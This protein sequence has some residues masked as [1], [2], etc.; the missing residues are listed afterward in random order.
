MKHIYIIL[1]F[2][3]SG[4]AL[5]NLNAQSWNQFGSFTNFFNN[6]QTSFFNYELD[7]VQ[8]DFDLEAMDLSEAIDGL[9]QQIETNPLEGGAGSFDVFW[10][11]DNAFIIDGGEFNGDNSDAASNQNDNVNNVWNAELDNLNNGINGYQDELNGVN[12]NV[13]NQGEAQA[14]NAHGDTE[15]AM[16]NMNGRTER[17][18]KYHRHQSTDDIDEVFIRSLFSSALDLELA[19]GIEFSDTY[20]WG[21]FYSARANLIRVASVPTFRNNFETS[22]AFETSFMNGNESVEQETNLTLNAG[23]NTL[24]YHGEFSFLFL[25]QLGTIGGGEFRLYT[26]IG[27]D[28][29]S[30]APSHVN[31]RFNNR[32]GMTTGYGAQ[33]GAG[34][35][36]NLQAVSI[37]SYGTLTRGDVEV[38]ATHDGYDYNAATVNAGIRI[39]N[40][41]N[42]RYTLGQNSWAFDGQKERNFNRFTVGL[43]LDSL[44]RN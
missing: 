21:D 44:R 6:T 35:V 17:F 26:S 39:G 33:V 18:L 36:V 14:A 19:Y 4:I 32:V 12:L 22:W 9:N 42:I 25:P 27:F 23:L 13:F 8:N 7:G 28:L 38:S 11:T 29:S 1:I 15:L 43:L 34:F 5:P 3:V 41:M 2:L 16:T 24:M 40:A 30:Y 31:S 20:F 37:Y 10:N